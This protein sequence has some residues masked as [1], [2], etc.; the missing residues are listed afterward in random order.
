MSTKEKALALT[1]EL[2]FGD[3]VNCTTDRTPYRFGRLSSNPECHYTIDEKLNFNYD[4]EPIPITEEILK[5]NGFNEF[6]GIWD[7]PNNSS[8]GVMITTL[9]HKGIYPTLNESAYF[10]CSYVHELQRALRL[11]GLNDLADNLKV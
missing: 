9:R 5:K 11:C 3:W 4:I 10:V 7:F 1:K 6:G 2:T 8:F